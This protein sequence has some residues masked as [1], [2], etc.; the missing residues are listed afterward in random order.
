VVSACIASARPH[1]FEPQYHQKSNKQKKLIKDYD[2]LL[3]QKNF[4][5][6]SQFV[7]IL[8]EFVSRGDN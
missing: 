8:K 3:S 2:T 5:K 4:Y 1:I 7:P 6:L